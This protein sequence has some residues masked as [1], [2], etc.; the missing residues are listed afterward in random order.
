M[1]QGMAGIEE[2]AG[3]APG[4]PS[5]R[6]LLPSV[7]GSIEGRAG[8]ALGFLMILLIVVGPSVAPYSPSE[9]GAGKPLQTPSRHH[10][11]GTDEL[12]RDVASRFL[13]GGESVVVLPFVA[14]TVALAIGGVVGIVSAYRGGTADAVVAR[15]FDLLLVLPPLLVALVLIAGLGTSSRVII[16]TVAIV[17]TPRLGRLVR[18]A[19]V[20]VVRNDYVTA[21]QLR[22][23]RTTWIVR[24]TILPNIVGEVLAAYALYLTYCII[25]VAT[26]SFLGLGA[27]PPSSNWGLMVA[28]GRSF[29][30][31]NPWQA[32][33]AT[34][35]IAGVSVT[36][37]LLADAV[38]RHLV[39]DTQRLDVGT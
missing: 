19:A 13:N 25:F 30:E 16:L 32:V 18:G 26:L 5:E 23:E 14:I 34:L 21:A 15:L 31:V 22:G 1:I 4:D 35:G 10:L 29:I 39:R 38:D 12:G 7:L 3:P 28:D 33:A 27:Q 8:I 9:I 11:L 17:Y 37:T 2:T 20:G 6:G 36:F 24:H